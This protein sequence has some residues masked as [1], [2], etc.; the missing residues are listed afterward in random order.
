MADYGL[1][2]HV[3]ELN[4]AAARV[5]REAVRAFEADNPGRAAWVAGSIGPTNRTL[6]LAVDVNDPG[7]RTNV[8]ADFVSAYAEQARGLLEGGVD[9]LLVE[10]VFDTLVGKAALVAVE[11]ASRARDGR[12]ADA[13]GDDH[14]RGAAGPSPARRSRRS[15]TRS[16]TRRC[17]PS[18]STA[19][20][21]RRRCGRTSRSSRGSLP[22]SR[23]VPE[24]RPAE[25][26]RRLRR[27][28]GVDGEADLREF[29]GRAG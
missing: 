11:E 13:L 14:R 8:F 28:A 29:A 18:A 6:S 21:G 1:E 12:P 10:T 4:A 19:P 25:R 27:D 26:L 7:K 15:G 23:R 3:R 16:P 22:C 20:S 9:L 2:A 17:S 24:R 5:A